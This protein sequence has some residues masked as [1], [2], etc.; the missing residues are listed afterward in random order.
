MAGMTCLGLSIGL[1]G[2]FGFFVPSLSQEFGIG[3]AVINMAPVLLLLVP[4]LLSPFVG[5][6]VDRWPISAYSRAS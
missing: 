1:V 6:L 4:G 3:V 5:R 2:I